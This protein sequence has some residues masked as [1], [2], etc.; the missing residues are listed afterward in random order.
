MKVENLTEANV[1][2][3][4]E[5]LEEMKTENPDIDYKTY[6]MEKLDKGKNENEGIAMILD[7]LEMLERKINMIFGDHVLING[8]F[9]DIRTKNPGP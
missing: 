6:I 7:K 8:D 2:E 1:D 9:R 5:K 3:L 4:K